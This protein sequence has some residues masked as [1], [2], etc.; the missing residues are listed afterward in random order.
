MAKKSPTYKWLRIKNATHK[1]LDDLRFD[2]DGRKE[3]FD[4]LLNRLA[5]K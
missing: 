4:H 2:T 5:A 1:L 3:S